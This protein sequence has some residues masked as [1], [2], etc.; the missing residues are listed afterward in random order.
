VVVTKDK[1]IR[2]RPLERQ[3]L[4]TAGVRAFVLV[5]G[6]LRAVEMA[7]IFSA[8]MPAMLKMVASQ[9]P[10]FIARVDQNAKVRLLFP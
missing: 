9:P 4:T 7:A 6:R 1:K 2:K 3:A 8:A 10:P 5:S